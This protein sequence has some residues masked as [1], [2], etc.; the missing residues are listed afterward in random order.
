[1]TISWGKKNPKY[2][3]ENPISVPLRPLLGLARNPV[4]RQKAVISLA[5]L[6]IRRRHGT[7]ST[8][9][10]GLDVTSLHPRRLTDIQLCTHNISTRRFSCSYYGRLLVCDAEYSGRN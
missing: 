8:Q 10:V 6:S 4:V 2:S 3:E 5:G 7:I 1:M 9:T